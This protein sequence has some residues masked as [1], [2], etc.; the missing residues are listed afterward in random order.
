MPLNTQYLKELSDLF[1]ED[2][3]R[4]DYYRKLPDKRAS[5]I[6][7]IDSP[8]DASEGSVSAPSGCR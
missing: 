6:S 4:S 8:A 5:A 7:T 3:K 2:L 1:V